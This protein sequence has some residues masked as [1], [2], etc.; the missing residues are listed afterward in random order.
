MPPGDMSEQGKGSPAQNRSFT[1][2]GGKSERRRLSWS[3]PCRRTRVNFVHDVYPYCASF[4]PRCDVFFLYHTSHQ[5][6]RVIIRHCPY[7]CCR[8]LLLLLVLRV[9]REGPSS[10]ISRAS[11]RSKA[12]SETTRRELPYASSISNKIR[13]YTSAPD[14]GSSPLPCETHH[15]VA[16]M[17]SPSAHR[18]TLNE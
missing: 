8:L 5:T 15:S 13:T 2:R 16:E 9:E 6:R 1:I 18:M 7:T 17:N 10:I 12:T 11:I 3:L 4:R 14:Q